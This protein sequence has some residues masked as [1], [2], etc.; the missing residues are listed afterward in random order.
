MDSL[1]ANTM[2]LREEVRALQATLNGLQVQI[3]MLAAC[4]GGTAKWRGVLETALWPVLLVAC[5]SSPLVALGLFIWGSSDHTRGRAVRAALLMFLV[6][7]FGSLVWLG[8]QLVQGLSACLHRHGVE[9]VELPVL[10]NDDVG[11]AEL[12]AEVGLP[13]AAAVIAIGDAVAAAAA[14]PWWARAAVGAIDGVI[15]RR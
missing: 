11:V 5:L 8:Y 2:A 1:V 12:G 7:P 10:A 3:E 9:V 6:D 15:S 14:R 4:S 13:D